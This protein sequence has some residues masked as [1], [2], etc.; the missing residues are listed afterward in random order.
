M[1]F[2]HMDMYQQHTGRLV[3]CHWPRCTQQLE[4][5]NDRDAGRSRLRLCV[6]RKDVIPAIAEVPARW[7]T[8]TD[9]R[10]STTVANRFGIR[11]ST[12]EHLLAALHGVAWTT[13]ALFLMDQ[14]SRSW[15][16]A[17][18]HLWN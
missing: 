16:A 4:C 14:K 18:G 13:R 5:R 7:N 10:L 2:Q 6:F 9:T 15:T 12:I 17:R 1:N 11:V 8:V 3:Y